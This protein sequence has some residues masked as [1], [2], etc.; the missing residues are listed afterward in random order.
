MKIL[1]VSKG[2]RQ[3]GGAS[4]V[5]EISHVWYNQSGLESKHFNVFHAQAKCKEKRYSILRSVAFPYY[6]RDF[7][8]ALKS[9]DLVHFHD[10]KDAITPLG[11][12]LSSRKIPSVITHHDCYGFF[13]KC[14]YPHY[15]GNQELYKCDRC[16]CK[17]SMFK[18]HLYFSQLWKHKL[19]NSRRVFHIFPSE[20][21]C[22]LA[23]Q[24]APS[25]RNN[26]TVFPYGLD[27]K[28]FNAQQY[29]KPKKPTILL[30]ANGF[31]GTR[32][33]AGFALEALRSV[34]DLNPRVV[35]VGKVGT[36]FREAISNFGLDFQLLGFL[37]SPRDLSRIYCNANI[38]LCTSLADN[39]PLTV[40]E[41]MACGTPTIGFSAGGIPEITSDRKTG[42]LTP[43]GN[44]KKLNDALRHALTNP[45][46]VKIWSSNGILRA[47]KLFSRELF[48]ERHINLYQKLIDQN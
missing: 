7:S 34:S 5:A 33:G 43:I 41:T 3:F 29:P 38:F 2:N 6:T 46:K 22:K 40:I 27:L 21:I 1:V 44:Q 20:W 35:V 39:L 36:E 48:L 31:S 32:K 30:A 10:L 19:L 8:Y 4:L 23:L 13:R 15:I 12:K 9:C 16:E 17:P 42:L 45:D 18:P 11:I 24:S 26:H 25:W 14:N 47:K 28:L 37:N